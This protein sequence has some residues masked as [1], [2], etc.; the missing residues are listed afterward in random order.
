MSIIRFFNPVAGSLD[1]L[2]EDAVH[3]RDRTSPIA[4]AEPEGHAR[5]TPTATPTQ[6]P[7]AELGA[8][9]E[10]AAGRA[11]RQYRSLV[12]FLKDAANQLE[13]LREDHAEKASALLQH[14]ASNQNLSETIRRLEA[15]LSERNDEHDAL[16]RDFENVDAQR[17]RLLARVEVSENE[18]DELKPFKARCY[19]LEKSYAAIISELDQ[20]QQAQAL[21]QQQHDAL[22][23]EKAQLEK[24]YHEEKSGF[25]AREDAYER[26]DSER[27]AEI[28]QLNQAI[29]RLSQKATAL[30]ADLA[31]V[32][33]SLHATQAREAALTESL[34]RLRNDHTVL[35]GNNVRMKKEYMSQLSE[36]NDLLSKEKMR[37]ELL[38]E[39]ISKLEGASER[40]VKREQELRDETFQFRAEL[41]EVNNALYE[42]EK[43]VKSLIG[44]RDRA[45]ALADE[46]QQEVHSLSVQ[47]DDL[48]QQ[49]A[50]LRSA[51]ER[52]AAKFERLENERRSSKKHADDLASQN[53][54]LLRERD[55]LR[56]ERALLLGQLSHYRA[57][58]L[59]VHA[60]GEADNSSCIGV[61]FSPEVEQT[62]S[63]RK[64]AGVQDGR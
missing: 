51:S 11:H 30:E 23:F 25:A 1:R 37:S 35:N 19:E 40:A 26:R 14:E 60:P 24:E 47:R 34:Q 15:Q 16:L 42:K 59:S 41:K 58:L 10:A 18:R 57:G 13:E 43:Q 8:E 45:A 22:K 29:S 39:K 28:S 21:L 54:E 2:A 61:E 38:R 12:D 27:V 63:A 64:E 32:A 17:E 52:D 36:A 55:G 48:V 50:A 56:S 33:E 49:V 46:R 53:D 9:A 6:R 44:A 31:E 20:V 4:A 5:P 3:D 62:D 7:T